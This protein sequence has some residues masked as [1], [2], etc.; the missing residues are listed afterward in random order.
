MRE[1]MPYAGAIFNFRSMLEYLIF[2]LQPP[3]SSLNKQGVGG[4]FVLLSSGAGLL[5]E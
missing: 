4:F 1:S 2:Y 3:T 5:R